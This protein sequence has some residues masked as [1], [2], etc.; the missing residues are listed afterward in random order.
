MR[1]FRDISIRNKLRILIMLISGLA[2]LLTC[3]ILGTVE[4]I[5]FRRFLAGEMTVLSE[6]VASRSA[7]SLIFNDSEVA[8]E[9]LESLKAKESIEYAAIY[10]AAGNLFAQ[11]RRS[12]DIRPDLPPNGPEKFYFTRNALHIVCPITLAADRLGSVYIRSDLNKM[13]SMIRNY[14]VL[15]LVIL[16]G[17]FLVVFLALSIMQ[18]IITKPILD[19]AEASD[20]IARH[21]N[22]GACVKKRGNDELGLLVDA[23]NSML[24]QLR[25]RDL[26][27]V[28]AKN[29]AEKSAENTHRLAEETH[30][31][32]LR[33]K[34]E[35]VERKLA[36]A[37]M[38]ESEKK[39]RG[40][41]ENAQEGIYRSSADNRFIDVNPSMVRLLGYDSAEDVVSHINDIG[42]DLF[43][44]KAERRQFYIM[45]NDSGAVNN[46]ECQLKRKDG[47]RIWVSVQARAFF[48]DHEKIIYVE[49][50]LEDITDRKMAAEAL[51]DS[52]RQLEKRVE[53]RTSEL[54]ATNEELLRAK[55]AA[56]EAARVKS[57][58]L[59][60]MSHEIRTP[61]NGVI[62]AA[63]LALFEVM[64]PK[65][66]H[67]LK[68]IHSSGNALLGIINDILDFSKIGAGKLKLDVNP[69]NLD[70]VISNVLAIF[71][72]RTAEKRIE[73]LLDVN[74]E[75][76]MAVVG[77]SLRFQQILTNLISNAVK[78]TDPSGIV[79]ISLTHKMVDQDTIRVICTVKDSGIGMAEEHLNSLFKAFTQGDTSTT[80]KYGG[81][82][83]GLCISQQLAKLMGGGIMVKS[84]FRKGS[85]FTV[86]ANLGRRPAHPE[87]R[88]EIPLALS[89]LHILVVDD[90]PETREILGK[91]IRSFGFTSDMVESG[92]AACDLLKTR[93]KTD[94]PFD[95]A[96]IDMTMPEMDGLRTAM[97]LRGELLFTAPIILM[98]EQIH[99]LSDSDAPGIGINRFLLKPVSASSL[100]NGIMDA[101]GDKADAKTH[102]RVVAVDK[103]SFFRSKLA[104]M[105]VLVVEDNAVNQE[106]A[107]EILKSVGINPLIAGDGIEALELLDAETFDAVLMDVQ[108]PRMDGYEATRKIHENKKIQH[109]P[110]IAMTASAMATDE[111]KC[112]ESGMTAYIT[113]PINQ[114]ILFE[115]MLQLVRP[116]EKIGD[117]SKVAIAARQ[118]AQ[119][120]MTGSRLSGIDS[121][122]ALSQLQIDKT[123]Y[124]NILKIFYRQNQG[125]TSSF[126]SALDNRDFTYLKALAHSLKSSSGSVGAYGVQAIAATM[127]ALSSQELPDSKKMALLSFQVD[128]LAKEME[129]VMQSLDQ[130]FGSELDV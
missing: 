127:E 35:I 59:A 14:I 39:Y 130:A 63:D 3:G 20:M 7:A 9:T 80:R 102:P 53:E 94:R 36:Y 13:Y 52:Y 19:L 1:R 70:E 99:D 92:N 123:T 125:T 112:F 119:T 51:K 57:E 114:Q 87:K 48:D 27:L 33:L 17:V 77:D 60:N 104:G 31:V 89:G 76:P 85:E 24:D 45:L 40:I 109:I 5:Q 113:K 74:P 43:V 110:V 23:F 38:I 30:E 121:E 78:F 129:V 111:K 37:A 22:F 12:Q 29:R 71:Q 108:M 56:D 25:Q 42:A 73:M 82:G 126:R 83:L 46:F 44:D 79:L 28:D 47:K 26:A 116:F 75:T 72:G 81:T 93:Q 58:F 101:F 84:E 32:N 98:T 107:V 8:T 128:Q 10:D 88:L 122:R 103:R 65:T 2:L 41:F 6:I 54:K 64:P 16:F 100:L 118:G 68:I 18:H 66:E 97:K 62:S 95:M 86:T 55:E 91:I 115:T 106:I 105:R 50:L 15:V 11:Y 61:L 124:Y 49:G 21:M 34:K 120:L 117:R 69:F 4:V 67:Y 90:C 96:V